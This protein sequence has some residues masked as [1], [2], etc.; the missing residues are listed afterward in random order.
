[1]TDLITITYVVILVTDVVIVIQR[2]TFEWRFRSSEIAVS[3][4]PRSE[5][6]FKGPF[7]GMLGFNQV[8][9]W[10]RVSVGEWH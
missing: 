1:M 6:L 3:V 2:L 8:L 4:F 5:T 7:I 9:A 10:L